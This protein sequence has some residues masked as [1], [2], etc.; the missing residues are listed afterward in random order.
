MVNPT[1][2]NDMSTWRFRNLP[3]MP[4]H[5]Q[6]VYDR[7]SLTPLDDLGAD[8]PTFIDRE[9]RAVYVPRRKDGKPY[10]HDG[11]AKMLWDFK[12]GNLLLEEAQN[13]RGSVFFRRDVDYEGDNR[14]LDSWHAIASIADEYNVPAREQNPAWDR[15][16]RVECRK[17]RYPDGKPARV[18][19]GIRFKNRAFYRFVRTDGYSVPLV[20]D[21]DMPEIRHAFELTIDEPWDEQL[22]GQ[23]EH[24]LRF[25][26][27]SDASYNNLKYMPAAPFLEEF[28]HLTFVLAGEGSNGKGTLFGAFLHDEA[29]QRLATTVDVERLV[30]GGKTSSTIA[31]QEPGKLIGKM[32]AFDEDAES[33]TSQQ[34]TKL[35]KLSTGD[36]LSARRL[37]QNMV[38]FNPR[39]TLCIA[40][41]LDFV[42]DMDTSMARRFMFV[43]MRDGRSADELENLRI[44][45]NL[46]GATPF[47]QLSCREW[48]ITGTGSEQRM[49]VN[50]GRPEQLDD[51]ETW[52]AMQ[53][54]RQGY[55][56]NTDNPNRTSPRATHNS[57]VKLG[58]AGAHRGGRYVVEVADETRFQPYRRHILDMFDTKGIPMPPTPIDC[59][60]QNPSDHGF[61][62]QYTPAGGGPDGKIARNWKTLANDP[63]TDTSQ[64][65]A[66]TRAWSCVPDAGYAI[67]DFDRAHNPGQQDG[68]DAFSYDV[69][70]YGSTAF[71]ATFMT[72]TPS[73]GRHAY[74]RLPYGI[75]LKDSNHKDGIPLDVKAE[76]QGYVIA[77]GSHTGRGDYRVCDD[78]AVATMSDHM[79]DWLADHGYV[80]R[81]ERPE[82]KAKTRRDEQAD[83]NR[84]ISNVNRPS[85]REVT[86]WFRSPNSKHAPR[87]NIP[88]MSRGDTHNSLCRYAWGITGAAV[89]HDWDERVIGSVFNDLLDRVPASHDR[90]QTRETITSAWRKRSLTVPMSVER[91]LTAH[92][93]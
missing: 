15:L 19:H 58:L 47:I 29:T 52:M 33:L 6:K 12:T 10:F 23:A 64:P 86:A 25:I 68:W 83:T 88:M 80:D 56:E 67:L 37:G 20:V 5:V 73:G 28:K 21:P 75:H 14:I 77:P 31:E 22:I 54:V 8:E 1:N 90:R 36:T 74:Y 63:H 34:T 62:C 2:P 27:D 9:G 13:D 50:I 41:N 46:H 26:T 78:T 3:D 42:T 84:D 55:F 92:G 11:Y 30:G 39:A 43:R 57:Y 51:A 53:I 85:A 16:M 24:W 38:S 70:N 45:I 61:A 82:T 49:N 65:P 66:N 72:A 18:H 7:M 59:Q 60:S 44:F 91:A 76:G 40:T 69:G 79:I 87:L 93:C 17:L 35:K 89:E 48:M 32:W 71:P 81:D 4:M